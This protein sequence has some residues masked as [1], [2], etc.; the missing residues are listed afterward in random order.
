V[1]Q[2]ATP[3]NFTGRFMPEDRWIG[4]NPVVHAHVF[5]LTIWFQRERCEALLAVTIMWHDLV[6]W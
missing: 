5:Y 6:P 3:V 4:W 1:F 2:K